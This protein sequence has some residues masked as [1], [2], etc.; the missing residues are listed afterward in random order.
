M[1]QLFKLVP[2]AG[3]GKGE[4]GYRAKFVNRNGGGRDLGEIAD[5]A[6]KSSRLMDRESMLLGF[7]YIMNEAIRGAVETGEIQRLGDYGALLLDPKGRFYGI[8]DRFDPSRH[9]VV[10]R[11]RKGPA[12]K[13]VVPQFEIENV[14]KGVGLIVYEIAPC[15]CQWSPKNLAAPK[16]YAVRGYDLG[17]NTLHG[18]LGER[19]RVLWSVI[20]DDETVVDGEFTVVENDNGFTRLRWPTDMP[21]DI[22]KNQLT[23]VF[24]THGGRDDGTPTERRIT[25]PVYRLQG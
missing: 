19:D 18:K 16:R 22:R 4:S 14:I 6:A 24:V 3:M 8:N 11:F 12:M 2:Y 1:K 20:R 9:R 21:T 15:G 23:V 10:F 17:V 5:Q 25:L 7:Q 13:D